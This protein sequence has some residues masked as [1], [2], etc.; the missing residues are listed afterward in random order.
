MRTSGGSGSDD[1]KEGS[2]TEEIT[3]QWAVEPENYAVSGPTPP[4][5]PANSPVTSHGSGGVEDS[6]FTRTPTPKLISA[7]SA[8]VFPSVLKNSALNSDDDFPF[9]P[10]NSTIDSYSD[11]DDFDSL[12]DGEKI[13]LISYANRHH[14]KF[15]N[16]GGMR[17][18]GGGGVKHLEKDR[19][20]K[21]E[22]EKEAEQLGDSSGSDHHRGSSLKTNSS[23]YQKALVEALNTNTSIEKNRSYDSLRPS[24]ISEGL[25]WLGRDAHRM[26]QAGPVAVESSLNP[27]SRG[28][29][30]P[31]AK[32]RAKARGNILLH[33][34]AGIDTE[35]SMNQAGYESD[36][37]DTGG[38]YHSIIKLPRVLLFAYN[39]IKS[40]SWNLGL[41]MFVASSLIQSLFL[42]L[43]VAIVSMHLGGC[44]S[45]F[46]VN[47]PYGAPVTT[48]DVSASVSNCDDT[49]SGASSTAGVLGEG[50]VHGLAENATTTAAEVT[51]ETTLCLFILFLASSSL[52]T[53]A[54]EITWIL[55]KSNVVASLILAAPL[56]LALSDDATLLGRELNQST[57]DS[58]P[59]AAVGTDEVKEQ[60]SQRYQEEQ[61][62]KRREEGPNDG[63]EEVL[64]IEPVDAE[65]LPR[66]HPMSPLLV[67]VNTRDQFLPSLWQEV[68]STFLIL[69]YDIFLAPIKTVILATIDFCQR[70]RNLF[71][72]ICSLLLLGLTRDLTAEE[73][74]CPSSQGATDTDTHICV[75]MGTNA[76]EEEGTC[77]NP[78]Q[79][80]E[81][82]LLPLLPFRQGRRGVAPIERSVNQM[83]AAAA[84]FTIVLFQRVCQIAAKIASWLPYAHLLPPPPL[85]TWITCMPETPAGKSDDYISESSILQA[86]YAMGPGELRQWVFLITYDPIFYLSMCVLLSAFTTSLLR[87]IILIHRLQHK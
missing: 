72:L 26:L 17:G 57:S 63:E 65:V 58:R 2:V 35:S 15:R 42:C 22:D 70:H 68:L 59:A 9:A 81:D 86:L 10:N 18:H 51:V 11:M 53:N 66:E 33:A 32:V 19:R 83:A 52:V 80:L 3:G 56:K 12:S 79:D 37:E 6:T 39:F 36:V 62:F 38:P 71:N 7:S 31:S 20:D 21:K 40:W 34:D 43:V 78:V 13:A 1:N 60:E 8:R 49:M 41:V 4:N 64:Q 29:S 27:R 67:L 69:L 48:T 47:D 61:G 25:S 44:I 75:G 84:T 30:R 45:S 14:N 54:M 77:P 74:I 85:S 76:V 55:T 28:I 73:D 16:K 23:A 82:K 24:S 46:S 50:D 5:T 87:R